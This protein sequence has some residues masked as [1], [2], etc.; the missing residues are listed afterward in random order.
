MSN[1]PY[2]RL[3]TFAPILMQRP[4]EPSQDDSVF[5]LM[6]RLSLN[7]TYSSPELELRFGKLREDVRDYERR[8]SSVW[9]RPEQDRVQEIAREWAELERK[10]KVIRAGGSEKDSIRGWEQLETLEKRSLE[11]LSSLR[12]SL[13]SKKKDLHSLPIPSLSTTSEDCHHSTELE[14]LRK[15]HSQLRLELIEVQTRLLSLERQAAK[16]STSVR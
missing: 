9:A 12:T 1:S 5:Y 4:S 3:S 6:N 16:Q 13:Q 8:L 14:T 10:R 11:R 2:D 15:A 7:S